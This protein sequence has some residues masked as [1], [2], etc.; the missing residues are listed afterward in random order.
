MYGQ[1]ILRAE[2]GLGCSREEEKSMAMT[3]KADFDDPMDPAATW[4]DWDSGPREQAGSEALE[5]GDA[6]ED[7]EEEEEEEEDDEDEDEDELDGEDEDGLPVIPR[8][9]RLR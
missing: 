2:R 9:V 8:R 5:A 6:V 1:C 3:K 4:G 7:E